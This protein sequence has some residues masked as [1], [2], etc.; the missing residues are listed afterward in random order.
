MTLYEVMF[1]VRPDVEGDDAVDQQI[2]RFGRLIVDAGGQVT[3]VD[4]WGRRRFAY[5]I[6]NYTEGIYV[7]MRFKAADTVVSEL[8]R[9]M[10]IADEVLR[11]LIVRWDE[12]AVT[13]ERKTDESDSTSSEEE[14]ASASAEAPEA[15][16]AAAEETPEAPATETATT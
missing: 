8:N 14:V 16:D 15:N 4:K 3:A 2:E 13:V 7:V 6:Q 11:H 12:P 10:R 1:I 9:I 5:A